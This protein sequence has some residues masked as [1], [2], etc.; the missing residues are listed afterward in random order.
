VPTLASTV[1]GYE[2]AAIYGLL[3]PAKTPPAIINALQRAVV[4]HLKTPATRERLFNA[5]V[6]VVAGTPEQFAAMIK[7]DVAKWSRVFKDAGVKAD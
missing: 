4:E 5:G 2:S 7:A 3:A 6:E 1:P